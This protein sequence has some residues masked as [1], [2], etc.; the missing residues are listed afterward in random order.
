[1]DSASSSS[2]WQ[3]FVCMRLHRSRCQNP[4]SSPTAPRGT[5]KCLGL[6]SLFWRRRGTFCLG[7]SQTARSASCRWKIRCSSLLGKAAWPRFQTQR[8]L[9]RPAIS[10][11]RVGQPKSALDPF[12]LLVFRT[13]NGRS[14][15]TPVSADRPFFVR[16]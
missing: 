3:C 1:M 13:P 11:I 6:G 9:P 4:K 2:P 8:S 14:T 10:R 5:R 7:S 16:M 15:Y 12:R